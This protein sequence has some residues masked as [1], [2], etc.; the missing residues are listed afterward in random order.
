MKNYKNINIRF[1]VLLSLGIAIISSCERDFSDDVQFA[2]FN[3]NGDIFTDAPV[4]LTDEFFDSFDPAGPNPAN[5]E[6][7]GT[8]DNVAFMGTSSIRI[9]VPAPDD[10]DGGFIGGIFL[11]RG[12]GRDLTGFDALTFYIKGST[13][14]TVGEVGFGTD[15]EEN[16]FAVIAQ[17]IRLSTDW[18]KIVIPIPDPS[19]LVQ[20]RGMFFFSAGTQS[21]G[22]F[23]YTFWIDELRF[24]KLGNIAQ[25]SPA[26]FSGQDISIPAV[27]GIEFL[28]TGLTQTFNLASGI[29]QTVIAAP[30]YFDFTSSD[31]SVAIVNESG[32]IV[33]VGAGDTSITAQLANVA[34]SGSLNISSN[35][36]LPTAPLPAE[37][38][39]NV[40]SIFS[41]E[42]TNAV[43]SNLEP[44][45]G[46]STTSIQLFPNNGDE[47]LVY[48]NNNFT[49]IVFNN[50]LD[51]TS[52]TT[53]NIDV[54]PLDE[55]T[56][57]EVQIR[58][59]GANQ[60][61]ETNIFT[62]LPDGDDVDRR[63]LIN[64]L[65]P[66]QWTSVE[67]PLDGDLVAQRNNLGAL[68]LAG[69]PNFIF[70]NIYFF[71]E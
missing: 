70:D 69:G 13:T 68:I 22:G 62:G 46:G 71:T 3:N 27:N 53:L 15:F 29:N 35:G 26:I 43:E 60:V 10:P 20:E 34:A 6:G 38:A 44:T 14:A 65:T 9:D 21:T 18:R 56:A 45:F 54:Y 17:N 37:S 63:F 11:D 51:G 31:N 59:V 8:D 64:G 61:L 57:V 58:D 32:E 49:G 50:T 23:G 25:P 4:G 47:V 2:T 30:A 48:T 40:S 16:K 39:A 33:V 41:N 12:D 36:V 52:R 67:I 1:I 19:K 55:S 42:F 7:F 66:G 28:V 5:P 24:E